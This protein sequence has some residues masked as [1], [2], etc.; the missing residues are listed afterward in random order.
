MRQLICI[1]GLFFILCLSANGQKINL[2][3]FESLSIR[4]IGPAGMSGRVTAIDVNLRDSDHIYVG[5]ASGGVWVSENGGLS[6]NPIFDDQATL[7]IGSIKINQNNPDEIWVGTGEGNPRNSLNVGYGIYKTMDGGKTWK[8]MGLENTRVIHRIIIHPDNPNVVLA[9]ATGSP[10]GDSMDRG[11]YRTEDGGLTWNKVLYV[12]QTTGVADMVMDPSNPNRIIAAMWEHR[13]TPWDF[14]SGGEGSGMH[15]SYDAGKTWKKLGVDEGMPKGELGR[16]GIAFAPSSSN[17][18]YALIEAKE[19]GFYKSVD[20]GANWSLVSQKNIG[21]RPFYYS[22]IYV[23]P[24]NENRIYNLWSYVSKSEDGGKTFETIMDY[25][26][27]IHPDHHA[28]WIHPEDPSYIINGNDGGMTISRDRGESWQFVANLPVGQFYHV[29]VDNDFPYNVYGG[30][31]DNGSWVGPG[32]VLKRGGIRNYDWQELYF[33]DGFDVAPNPEDN[34]YGYAMSQGGNLA[35]YDREMGRTQS[36]RPYSSDTI[37]LRFN[38]NAPLAQDPFNTCGVYYGS[39]FVHYS[40]DC[41]KSWSIISPDLTTNDTLKQKQDVS[42]GLTIDATN[43]E[44]HTTLICIAPSATNKDEI[45]ASSDDGNLQVTRDGGDQWMNVSSKLSGLPKGSYIPQIRLSPKGNG[46]AFVVA[47]N[48]RRN[49]FSAYAYHTSNYGKSWTRIADDSQ[50]KGF[51]LSII[52]DTEEENLLFLGTDVGLYFSLDKGRNWQLWDKGFPHVQISD[53]AFQEDFDD[54]IIGTFGRSFWVFDDVEVLRALARDASLLNKDFKVIG[55]PTAYLASNRSYD[56]IRFIAQGEFVGQNKGLGAY[57]Y[58]WR[59]PTKDS[60]GSSTKEK[61]KD[62]DG[63]S[64]GGKLNVIVLS[65]QGDTIRTYKSKLKD[66][67]NKLRWGMNRNGVEFPSRTKP[68]KDSDA[69]RGYGVL[70]GN[71]I[72]HFYLDG[73]KDSTTIEV[74]NDPRSSTTT[75]DM[76][77]I[78]MVYDQFYKDVEKATK[79]IHRVIDAKKSLAL[80]KDLLS[81]QEDSI[82]KVQLKELKEVKK[83]L[84]DLEELYF[85]PQGLKGIQRDPKKLSNYLWSARGMIGSSW[86]KPGSNAMIAFNK[87]KAKVESVVSEIDQFFKEKYDPLKASIEERKLNPFGSK[88]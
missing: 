8:S 45:W 13:R 32:F 82:S 37:D 15:I 28:L 41:G 16:I 65:E 78:H 12:N 23:D 26:N 11:V 19:N 21:N 84:T 53:L 36:I 71:Y 63:G 79:G 49:D 67:L 44:N 66:G 88:E 51:V 58:Y 64:K 73:M 40:R 22:E 17:I 62:E 1:T 20:G 83:G 2:D 43:A 50:I 54:L 74:R 48:Y 39:Q 18:V 29:N 87:A 47:N 42:G 46:E 33:G 70:P 57:F 31:Q 56:G 52:Q 3:D 85:M 25:G 86:E 81:V 55:A 38:W 34:R 76:K 4:N 72:V 59:K 5:T 9:G 7:S 61:S 14:V 80:V 27:N 6:W 75:E 60:D 68:K 35:Y 69:P 10:W 30:M 77:D 24:K